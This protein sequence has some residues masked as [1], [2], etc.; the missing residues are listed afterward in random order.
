MFVVGNY[1][2]LPVEYEI[3]KNIGISVFKGGET[4]LKGD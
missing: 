4:T 3:T 1:F 2:Q